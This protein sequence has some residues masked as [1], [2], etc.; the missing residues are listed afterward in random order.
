MSIQKVYMDSETLVGLRQ[1]LQRAIVWEEMDE[2][3]VDLPY[4][5]HYFLGFFGRAMAE[6]KRDLEQARGE[7]LSLAQS[8]VGRHPATTAV[9]P[10]PRGVKEE[11]DE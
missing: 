5:V 10:V 2:D 6:A 7:R 8:G 3:A 4:S 9:G 1:L 11:R